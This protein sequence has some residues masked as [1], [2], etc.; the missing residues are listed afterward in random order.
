MGEWV[1]HYNQVRPHSALGYKP[2]APQAR[3]PK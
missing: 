3:Y 1:K 2:P